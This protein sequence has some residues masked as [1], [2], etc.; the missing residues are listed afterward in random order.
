MENIALKYQQLE[1]TPRPMPCRAVELLSYISADTWSMD[2]DRITG[3]DRQEHHRAENT[4]SGIDCMKNLRQDQHALSPV[5][6][7]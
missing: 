4:D 5:R 7:S 2:L 1:K 6:L 3:C